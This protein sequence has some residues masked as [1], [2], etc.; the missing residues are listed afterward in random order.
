MQSYN[1]KLKYVKN[2]LASKTEQITSFSCHDSLQNMLGCCIS[3]YVN[4]GT[5]N[6][7]VANGESSCIDCPFKAVWGARESCGCKEPGWTLRVPSIEYRDP[8]FLP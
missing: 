4:K 5:A 7:A 6:R 3:S 1:Q 8:F 2:M